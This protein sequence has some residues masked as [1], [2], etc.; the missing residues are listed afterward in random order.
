MNRPQARVVVTV[1]AAAS[2]LFVEGRGSWGG[3][4]GPTF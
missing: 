3:Q 1:L 4:R 2:G